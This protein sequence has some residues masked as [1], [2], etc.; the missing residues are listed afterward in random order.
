MNIEDFNESV[1]RTWKP[2]ESTEISGKDMELLHS[3]LLLAD[4]SGEFISCIKKYIVYKQEFDLTN[5][6][7]ELGDIMYGVFA[8]ANVMGIP[9]DYIMANNKAKLDV[10]FP[11]GYSDEYAKQRFDKQLNRFLWEGE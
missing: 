3:A 10:R 6:I 7:E 2:F 8:A 5:A 9:V 4:E 11:D 1:K